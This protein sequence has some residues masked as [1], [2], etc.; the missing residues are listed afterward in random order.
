MTTT[1]FSPFLHT[2][3]RKCSLSF[4]K[5][6]YSFQM[7]SLSLPSRIFS[8]NLSPQRHLTNSAPFFWTLAPRGT[9][10]TPYIHLKNRM[11]R[12]KLHHHSQ[13]CSS[14]GLSSF[15]NWYYYPETLIINLDSAISFG[16][17]SQ[18][19]NNP[20][21]FYSLNITCIQNTVITN[22]HQHF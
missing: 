7:V 15:S 19:I 21:Q 11:C 9:H 18:L 12:A 5:L 2:W 10:C 3:R 17:H 16:L 22:S 8:F 13:A 20:C 14:S 4:S 6:I 1:I